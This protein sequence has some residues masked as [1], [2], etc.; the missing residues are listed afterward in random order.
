MYV[1]YTM[2][3]TVEEF[4]KLEP[5]YVPPSEMGTLETGQ[6]IGI[7]LEEGGP[8]EF[9]VFL[10]Y[11]KAGTIHPGMFLR[12]YIRIR[13]RG[14]IYHL[15]KMISFSHRRENE[16]DPHFELPT[17][18][19]GHVI[20]KLMHGARNAKVD[21][22]LHLWPPASDVMYDSLK[23]TPE[24]RPSLFSAGFGQATPPT[25]PFDAPAFGQAAP[26]NG[27][28]FSGNPFSGGQT[29]P[30]VGLFGA[31]VKRTTPPPENPSP[32]KK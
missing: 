13:K 14:K 22:L 5:V 23:E 4:K 29:A 9:G 28:P 31:G 8:P 11:V 10:E 3:Q 19:A 18:T 30:P 24:T 1:S 32:F 26:A 17:S 16:K 2:E 21:T 20:M 6:L 15:E 7:A 27:N 25:N 12:Y